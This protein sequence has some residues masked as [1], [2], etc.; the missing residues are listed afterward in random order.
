MVNDLVLIVITLI[1]MVPRARVER[2]YLYTHHTCSKL[3]DSS[4]LDLLLLIATFV[5]SL[6]QVKLPQ[7]SALEPMQTILD[8]L[9]AVL[10]GSIYLEMRSI[11]KEAEAQ[12]PGVCDE[13][14][15]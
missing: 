6:A 11:Q 5:V 13:E 12:L 7:A 3:V 8:A 4:L 14:E 10:A 1:T 15:W 9:N 2:S